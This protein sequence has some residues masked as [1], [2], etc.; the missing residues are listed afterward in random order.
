MSRFKCLAI[1]IAIVS[2]VSIRGGGWVEERV[3]NPFGVFDGNLDNQNRYRNQ[4]YPNIDLVVAGRTG[5]VRQISTE[6]AWWGG[7]TGGVE[8]TFGVYTFDEIDA[9]VADTSLDGFIGAADATDSSPPSYLYY[10]RIRATSPC[11]GMPGQS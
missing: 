9:A 8:R 7:S 6:S 4:L 10:Y 11:K 5:T 2:V 3:A 1:A